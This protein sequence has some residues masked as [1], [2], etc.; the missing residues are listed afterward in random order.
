MFALRSA[1]GTK[2]AKRFDAR[3]LQTDLKRE[4]MLTAPDHIWVA[5][6]SYIRLPEEFVWSETELQRRANICSSAKTTGSAEKVNAI[7]S[8]I[9][10]MTAAPSRICVIPAS[11]ASSRYRHGAPV[12][13]DERAL[14]QAEGG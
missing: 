1:R 5:D 12:T 9:R 11:L 8:D 10:R 3:D 2:L 14:R 7:V 4:A 13:F 6:I